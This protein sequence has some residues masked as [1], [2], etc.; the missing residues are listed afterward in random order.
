MSDI[1]QPIINGVTVSLMFLLSVCVIAYTL[2]RIGPDVRRSIA[3]LLRKLGTGGKMLAVVFLLAA[4]IHGSTKFR[5]DQGNAGADEGIG[6]VAIIADY[7]PTNDV[8]A[9]SVLYMGDGV[10]ALTPVS[11]RN[12]QQEQWRLLDKIDPAIMTDAGTN[13]LSFTVAGNAETNRFWWIGYDTPAVIV[14]TTGIEITFFAASSHSVQISWT[15]DD[16]NATEF[17]IQRRRKRTTEWE[18]VGITSSLAF[19]YVGFTVGETWEWRVS[20]TYAEVE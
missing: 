11:V 18:T 16:P 3:A 10:T 15:C 12:S 9:V 17:A 13:T 4:V 1:L 7:D 5:P 20:S 6:L 8:T 2:L 19:V 14:E